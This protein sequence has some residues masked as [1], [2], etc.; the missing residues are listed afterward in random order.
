M[1]LLK[2]FRSSLQ[3]LGVLTLF[4]LPDVSWAQCAGPVGQLGYWVGPA[5]SGADSCINAGCPTDGSG[6]YP[7]GQT[8]NEFGFVPAAT[9]NGLAGNP[10]LVPTGCSCRYRW[11]APSC[12]SWCANPGGTWLSYRSATFTVTACSPDPTPPPPSPTGPPPLPPGC[13]LDP[14]DCNRQAS[15][16]DCQPGFIK[17]SK[18]SQIALRVPCNTV[19]VAQ[20]REGFQKM[21]DQG[22]HQLALLFWQALERLCPWAAQEAAAQT[23]PCLGG[24]CSQQ[25]LDLCNNQSAAGCTRT[26]QFTALGSQ[27][28]GCT[29]LASSCTVT[30]NCDPWISSG[31]LSNRICNINDQCFGKPYN[32][33]MP[34]NHSSLFSG[35]QI[36]QQVAGSPVTGSGSQICIPDCERFGGVADSGL[37]FSWSG[38]NAGKCVCANGYVYNRIARVCQPPELLTGCSEGGGNVPPS[39]VAPTIRAGSD[40]G[41]VGAFRN[42]VNKKLSCCLNGNPRDF[43]GRKFDCVDNNLAA[44]TGFD[45]LWASTDADVDGGQ[46]NALV[47]A[48]AGGVPLT[49]FYSVEGKRGPQFSEFSADAITRVVIDP[50]TN[51]IQ[52]TVGTIP[53]PVGSAFDDIV[54]RLGSRSVPTSVQDRMRYPILV[55][56]AAIYD[57]PRNPIHVGPLRTLQILTAGSVTKEICPVAAT[58]KIHFRIEQVGEILGTPPMKTIDS[59]VDQSQRDALSVEKILER[60]YG[61]PCAPGLIRQGDACV[62]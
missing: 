25:L 59:I 13:G 53:K 55:R 7:D 31:G 56:A 5:I 2:R 43:V 40:T 61:P 22:S 18:P 26:Y 36:K 46:L 41:L 27:P 9:I 52:T 54:N 42:A 30:I 16:C 62:Y 1:K 11:D 6:L 4:L 8:V 35:A 48:G 51:S 23:I 3:I 38:P 29:P 58:I 20:L 34:Y 24:H 33:C 21:R 17:V 15:T 49:G 19:E 60:K 28:S 37:R 50:K 32:T 39:E 57:C 12:T 47:L 45:A 10:T 14:G 44:P